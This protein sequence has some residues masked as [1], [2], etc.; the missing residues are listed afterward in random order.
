MK[1]LIFDPFAG[2]SGD[3]T[4]GALLDLG[5]PA[6]WL[7]EFVARL[8]LGDVKL[9]TERVQR[10]GISCGRVYFDLPHE[11]KH[12]HLRHI[13]EILDKA[14]LSDSVRE[15]AKDAFTRLAHAEAAVHGTT[16]EKVHFHEVGALDAILDVTCV[17]A[18]VEQLGFAEFYT[19]PVCLG[20]GWIEIEHGR[21]PVP[22]PATLR[23]LEGVAVSDGGLA[24]ECTTP[25]GA[26]IIA[27]LTR[28]KAPPARYRVL[29]SG[30]GAGTRDP[31]DRPNCVRLIAC[32]TEPV[33][34]DVFIVQSDIDDLNP[35]LV[36]AAQEALLAAG[37]FDATV[38]TLGM[39]KGRPAIRLEALVPEDSLQQVLEVLFRATTTIGA[40]YWRVERPSLARRE[41]TVEWRGHT[42]RVKTVSLPGGG[43]R[44]KPEH[45]DV[46]KAAQA[47]GLTA[48]E[49]RQ[50]VERASVTTREQP[51]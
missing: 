32:E 14:P 38:Q 39:K 9:V 40:R 45:E 16:I 3:M 11:H 1:A 27:T 49:V 6:E 18:G 12:R 51:V 48:L 35:E 30:F 43:T 26:A 15:R 31:D 33:A 4:L 44:T 24:G 5:L 22:A 17:M 8:D 41:E 29:Q 20:S 10:R 47:L 34:G 19:R 28:G 42:F 2:I 23:I 13:I 21:F 7:H 36:P 25:T 37:A 46:V 50:A